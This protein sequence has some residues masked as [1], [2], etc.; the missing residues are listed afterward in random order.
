[1][2]KNYLILVFCLLSA[3][4]FAQK[5]ETNFIVAPTVTFGETGLFDS[6]ASRFDYDAA[7][8]FSSA[9][10]E[11]YNVNKRIA[12]GSELNYSNSNYKMSRMLMYGDGGERPGPEWYLNIQTLNIPLI[13]R[14]Q[15][16]KKWMFQAG[17]GF[18][19]VLDSRIKAYRYN[20]RGTYYP[21]IKRIR[22][23]NAN[24]DIQGD[25]NSYYTLA[26]GKGFNL[27]QR[28]AMIQIYF[29]QTLKEYRLF[30]N[31]SN[32]N[33]EYVHEYKFKPHMVGLRLGINL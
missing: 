21:M 14:Y 28:T 19:Y 17:Y 27:K 29:E 31:W 18:T 5:F 24:F 13:L 3:I 7:F 30:D 1:M 33:S 2:T 12:I 4:A 26:F 11:F 23:E 32:P 6:G 10:Q 9:I 22:V 16:L 25:F 8:G 20:D 15:T